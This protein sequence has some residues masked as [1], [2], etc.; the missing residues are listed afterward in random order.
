MEILGD[1]HI[2][3]IPATLYKGKGCHVC[4]NSGF[5]GQIGIFEI[6]RVSEE[7]RSLLLKEVP[8]AE[9]RKAAIKEGMTTMFEDGL[10]KVESGVT[11][12]EEVLRVVR[13]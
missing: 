1:T 8:I 3:K 13:E 12:I 2:K 10:K 9:I 4:G 6:F 5:Q 11:T 7:I